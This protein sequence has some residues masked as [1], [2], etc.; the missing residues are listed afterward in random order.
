M[1]VLRN[2][3]IFLTDLGLWLCVDHKSTFK[4]AAL[5]EWLLALLCPL[6]T[7]YIIVIMVSV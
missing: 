3:D 1:T 4:H 7:E 6:C 5:C 2:V